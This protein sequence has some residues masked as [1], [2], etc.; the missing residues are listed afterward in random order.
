MNMQCIGNGNLEPITMEELLMVDYLFSRKC[1]GFHFDLNATQSGR[2][3][4]MAIR[5]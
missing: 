5:S 1:F 3:R 4:F 2:G